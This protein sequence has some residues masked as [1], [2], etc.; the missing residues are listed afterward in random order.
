M[1]KSTAKKPRKDPQQR[2]NEDLNRKA[3]II[4]DFLKSDILDTYETFENLSTKLKTEKWNFKV[5]NKKFVVFS[6]MNIDCCE[7]P[8][9]IC[10]IEEVRI[11]TSVVVSSNLTVKI[12]VN[13]NEIRL[14]LQ[15]FVQASN[16]IGK[17][18]SCKENSIP[19]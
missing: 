17:E 6:Q 12:Q 8:N 14:Q 16:R 2:K 13:G 15:H 10:D 4:E 11:V 3:A 1:T 9:E 18:A 7:V 19:R 5:Y